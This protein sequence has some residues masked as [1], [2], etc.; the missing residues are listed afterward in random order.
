M[1]KYRIEWK[2]RVHS[3]L[4]RLLE[5]KGIDP[6]V[7]PFESVITETPP[8]PELGDIAFPLFPYA[9]IMR[10]APA[11]IAQKLKAA[12]PAGDDAFSVEGPYLNIKMSRETVFREV[13]PAVI[14]AGENC[15]RNDN[16]KG[17]RV[18]LEFSCPNT[19][20]PLH[21]GH[22]RNDSLGESI[23]RIL[24]E[25]GAD[26]LKVNL[27]NDRGIHIAKSMLAY[28]KYGDNMTPETTGKKSDHFVGDYYVRFAQWVK[29]DPD[30]EAQ[31]RKLLKAWEDGDPQT[32]ELWKLMN[33]WAIDGIKKTYE[34]TGIS[35]DRYYFESK[36]YELGKA[37]VLKGLARGLFFK[38][39]DNSI[40]VDLTADGLDEKVL[41]R[42]DGTSL[43]LTQDIGTA[44]MR[45]ADWSFDRLLY[46]VASEQNYH[47]QVLFL[48]LKMLGFSWAEHLYHLS[49]GMVNLPEGKMKSR[50][51][52]VVD[53][54]DLLEELTGFALQEMTTRER[55]E[56]VADMAATAKQIAL[57]A[58]NYYLLAATPHKDI[59][60]NP[61][62]SL[63]FTGNTGPYL[64][65]TGARISSILRKFEE[66]KFRYEGGKVLYRLL[67]I[68]DEWELV[69]LFA[70][71]P[72]IV[73]RAAAELDPSYITGFLYESA[74]L[75]A[76]YYHDNQVL[77]NEDKDLVVTRI[78]LLRA[79]LAVLK[80]GFKLIGIPFL[81]TM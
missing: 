2:Q 10:D 15:G 72:L 56:Q 69:K 46:V 63:S 81:E 22:L 20:K 54:D 4:C 1:E 5:T 44:L 6:G 76:H 77:R 11:A 75:F 18:M 34:E 30:A 79:F 78:E 47:F 12:L 57:G 49:Y 37:E 17:R 7:L 62:D 71:Y 67:S 3:A 26:V 80:S 66:R 23:A 32:L 61:K 45:A 35:F 36:T 31:A 55:E 19:N 70:D 43:Y 16:M 25:C 9:K 24:K 38:K 8:Q 28:Q 65:Y 64:Q 48:V 27:I 73:K 68:G 50:E 14:R 52:T 51:G 59:I 33:N 29:D 53:A 21:L 39:E 40:W 13:I 42:S 60:F 41:L 58:L 74:K